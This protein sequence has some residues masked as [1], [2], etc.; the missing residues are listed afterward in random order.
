MLE[1]C[2]RL[3]ELQVYTLV[4][5]SAEAENF[6]QDKVVIMHMQECLDM[7]FKTEVLEEPGE[8]E[9]AC[10]GQKQT[11]KRSLGMSCLPRTLTIM[12]KRYETVQKLEY[13]SL[14]RK[15]VP[16]VHLVKVS[17]HLLL[18]VPHKAFI[19]DS[20]LADVAHTSLLFLA[21]KT[22]YLCNVSGMIITC[23]TH[24]AGK[25]GAASACVVQCD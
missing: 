1:L 15:Q 3:L 20:L 12:L 6:M 10:N 22:Q 21:H 7:H 25:L 11:T 8:C 2:W 24:C 18:H 5:S 23:V 19:S 13:D 16:K 9:G 17:L 4:P 14:T